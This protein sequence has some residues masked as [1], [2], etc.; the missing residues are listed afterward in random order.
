MEKKRLDDKQISNEVSTIIDEFVTTSKKAVRAF[1]NLM[2]ERT[3]QTAEDV[4]DKKIDKLKHK[5]N[6]RDTYEK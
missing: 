5:I 4:V 3:A 2:V 1:F 6:E